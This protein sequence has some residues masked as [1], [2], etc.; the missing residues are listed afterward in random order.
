MAQ[1][2]LLNYIHDYLYTRRI[3]LETGQGYID[4]E[5]IEKLVR[6]AKIENKWILEKIENSGGQYFNLLNYVNGHA[7]ELKQNIKM[8]SCLFPKR[9]VVTSFMI[10]DDWKYLLANI[11]DDYKDF[12][13]AGLIDLYI[14]TQEQ[15]AEWDLNNNN[16]FYPEI[17][18]NS[19]IMLLTHSYKNLNYN[20][21]K[22][23]LPWLYNARAEDYL[24]LI[25]KYHLQFDIY[26]RQ[27][28]KICKAAKEPEELTQL[29]IKEVKDAFID[30]RIALENKREE[31]YKKG[32]NAT[33]GSIITAIPFLIPEKIDFIS[34]EILSGLLGATNVLAT[35]PPVLGSIRDILQCEK[36]NEYWLLWKW[37]QISMK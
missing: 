8:L 18:D 32:I 30:I 35:L 21:I 15:N 4:N 29:F 11:Y 28:D 19:K 12:F 6:E 22:I 16:G 9:L 20:G 36:F 13:K 3:N 31:L 27:I 2:K 14:E 17:I 25:E 23:L 24:E 33:I 1:E 34:P 37:N 26:C 7:G 10:Q 5:T